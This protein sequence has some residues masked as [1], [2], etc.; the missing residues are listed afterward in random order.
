MAKPTPLEP[1]V[2]MAQRCRSELRSTSPKREGAFHRSMKFNQSDS[3]VASGPL[4]TSAD[5]WGERR[6]ATGEPSRAAP[7]RSRPPS[8]HTTPHLLQD[9][10]LQL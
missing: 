2:T 8:R 7:L 9:A 5:E 6:T 3:I 1:P 10:P 4:W